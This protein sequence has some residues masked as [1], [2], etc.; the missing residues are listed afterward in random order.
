MI[1]KFTSLSVANSVELL[2]TG[3]PLVTEHPEIRLRME[4]VRYSFRGS[5]TPEHSPAPDR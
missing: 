3:D 4:E 5:L 2:S 1:D